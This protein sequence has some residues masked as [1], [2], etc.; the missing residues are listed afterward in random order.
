MLENGREG[1][2]FIIRETKLETSSKRR[3]YFM[4]ELMLE[5]GRVEINLRKGDKT[6]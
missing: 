2:V 1:R 4:K 6:R 5:R 3:V